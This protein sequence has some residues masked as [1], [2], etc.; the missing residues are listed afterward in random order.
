[1]DIQIEVTTRCNFRCVYCAGRAM[2]QRD[3]AWETFAA[4]AEQLPGGCHTVVLQGEGEPTLHPRLWD[5]ARLVRDKGHRPYLI[6]NGSYGD[7]GRLAEH[8]P[9]IGISLDTLDVQEAE[10]IGRLNLKRVAANINA[11]LALTGPQRLTFH[12]TAFGQPLQAVRDMARRLGVRHLV[13]GLQVK[14]D[15]RRHYPGSPPAPPS[16]RP[17]FRCRYLEQTLMRFFSVDGIEMPCCYI[18][19]AAAFRSIDDLRACLAARTI[20][21]ACAGC[22][23]ILAPAQPAPVPAAVG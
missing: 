23:E 6:T 1:M 20:P 3:M 15:Y 8:F 11:L 13:Q 9:F 2:P 16:G 5:M 12:T 19:D 21:A 10:R 4:I 17:T 14:D 22:R 7:V 18:K